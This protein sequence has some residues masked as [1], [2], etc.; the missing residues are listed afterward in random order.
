MI[1]MKSQIVK[2]VIALRPV[3]NDSV[4]DVTNVAVQIECESLFEVMFNSF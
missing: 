3:S 4:S 1:A 2:S